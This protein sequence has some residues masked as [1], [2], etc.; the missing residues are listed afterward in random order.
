MFGGRSTEQ[1]HALITAELLELPTYMAVTGPDTVAFG[2]NY[3]DMGS[4]AMLLSHSLWFPA[5]YATQDA[6]TMR[7]RAESVEPCKLK[8]VIKGTVNRA[9]DISKI[10]ADIAALDMKAQEGGIAE[11]FLADMKAQAEQQLAMLEVAPCPTFVKFELSLNGRTA[12]HMQEMFLLGKTRR[13]S[14]DKKYEAE[15]SMNLTNLM[16]I[17]LEAKEERRRRELDVTNVSIKQESVSITV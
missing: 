5:D 9:R 4:A 10:K 11:S 3:N 7:A 13:I 15:L 2:S 8:R 16:Y 14:V 17:Y 12:A 1:I 6:A